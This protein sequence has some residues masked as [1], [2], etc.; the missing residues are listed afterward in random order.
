MNSYSYLSENQKLV[1]QA[2]LIER[3]KFL[4]PN[5][6]LGILESFDGDY[7][8][9]Y[10]SEQTMDAYFAIEGTTDMAWVIK[11][12]AEIVYNNPELGLSPIEDYE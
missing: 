2:L 9:D 6:V 1:L 12:F 7:Y 10:I 5:D 4:R 3:E 8:D 11:V